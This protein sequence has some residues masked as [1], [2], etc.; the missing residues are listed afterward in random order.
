[1][2]ES[3][4]MLHCGARTVEE[5]ELR[6][7]RAPPPEGRWY[8]IG[9]ARVLDT[10]K[11]TLT[12]AGYTVR[13]QKLALT[14]SDYRFFG[15]LD[16]ATTL[17]SEVTL[18][19]GIRNSIDKSFPMGFAA[20][21]R[22]F[23]CDNLAFRSE[24]MVKR[25]HTRFGEQRFTA[26]IAGAVTSLSDFREVE[27]S[28]IKRMTYQD[29]TDDQADAL[30]LRAFEKGI[31]T[32]PFLPR[33]IRE[34]RNPSFEEFEPRTAWSLLNAFTTV[35]GER[36]AKQPQAYTVQTMRLN[37]LLSPTAAA[38]EQLAQAT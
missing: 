29:L 12:E 1:M 9:H 21:S 28:R 16:L 23:C 14:K 31:V 4:L 3:Q 26:A 32:A 22:V 30:I 7:C 2:A 15:V 11:G 17:Y 33:V 5:D 18:A 10:V 34:W 24:L 37:S 25:K 8:P 13:S 6:A 20:G 38:E 27:A 36:A 35:L 19:V